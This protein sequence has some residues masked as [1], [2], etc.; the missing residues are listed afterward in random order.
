MKNRIEKLLNAQ[1][2][3]ILSVYFTAGFPHLN[4]TEAII[5][6]LSKKGVDMIE[7]GIPFSDPIAD[8]KVIQESSTLALRNGM[9]L[10]LLLDQLAAVRKYCDIPL[11][12]MGYLNPLL[13]FGM[14][15]LFKRCR[16][17][18]IDALIIPDLPFKEY[19]EHY[20]QWSKQYN[21]FI[22]MLITPETSEERIRLIDNYCGG[23][24]YMISSA[25]TT[26]I[27]DKF[28][29]DEIEYF[30]R[31]DRMHLKHRRLIGFGVSNS[32]TFTQASLY[33]S[34]VIVG[35][36]FIRCLSQAFSAEGAVDELFKKLNI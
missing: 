27:R 10:S 36:L 1:E 26:G 33:A 18:G 28:G 6:A 14:K 11:I 25:S 3:N 9:S 32:G 24:I 22:I 12:L 7:I 16:E 29:K 21:I 19:L 15:A 35:S 13:Q 17:V 31:I 34:G 2:K 5:R 20:Q 8:G 4:S 23:F 30:R